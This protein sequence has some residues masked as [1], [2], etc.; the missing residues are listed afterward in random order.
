MTNWAGSTYLALSALVLAWDIAVAGRVA[1]SPRTPGGFAAMTGLAGFLVL[2][3]LLLNIASSTSLAA[4][5]ALRVDWLWPLA[6]G[7]FAFQA[8]HAVARGL[9]HPAWG[10]P[11]AAYDVVLAGVELTHYVVAH[12]LELPIDLLTPLAAE[13]GALAVAFSTRAF[14]SPFYALIP[15]AVPSAPFGGRLRNAL[16][17]VFTATALSWLGLFAYE[18]PGAISALHSYGQYRRE[19]LRPRAA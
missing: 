19:P 13:R 14:A 3:A 11:I 7:L 15:I 4:S 2:P 5:A 9:V 16:H 1:E 6:V 8:V 10:S 12:G 18:V 17:G